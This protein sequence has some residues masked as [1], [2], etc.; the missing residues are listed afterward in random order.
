[1][2]IQGGGGGGGGASGTDYGA[3]GFSISS[4]TN[5][6]TG[7]TSSISSGTQSISTVSATGGI[8][9]INGQ[10]LRS[11]IGS[12][13]ALSMRGP[14]T[15]ASFYSGPNPSGTSTQGAG[16]YGIYSPPGGSGGAAIH[17]LSGLTAGLTLTCT[18]GAGG[19]AAGGNAQIPRAGGA[20]FIMIEW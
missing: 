8:G 2:T 9:G 7:G 4:Y 11:G 16:G 20:G 17:Y 12:G 6:G 15:I 13:G 3:C 5:G 19:A 1:M 10:P 14:E 18:V